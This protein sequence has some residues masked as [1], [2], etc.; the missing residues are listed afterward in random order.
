MLQKLK[1]ASGRGRRTNSR[2]CWPWNWRE[3]ADSPFRALRVMK[4]FSA[5]YLSLP[6]DKA[7]AKFW[8][9]LFPLPYKDDVFVNARERGLDPYDVAALI[10]QES[11][12]NPGAKSRA[13]AYGL[14]QLMPAT[15]RMVGPSAG[16]A[17]HHHWLVV[18]PAVSIQLGTHYLRQQLDGWDGDW[19][20]TLAAYNAGPGTGS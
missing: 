11:E 18:D 7:P 17:R 1:S 13:N 4:S 8:Q 14:M 16:H 12:F 20:R 6:L 9:M 3:S 19:F 5:D 2:N 15:G 10:R